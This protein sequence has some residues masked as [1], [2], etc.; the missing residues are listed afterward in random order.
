MRR[1]IQKAHVRRFQLKVLNIVTTAV[2]KVGR[3]FG[4]EVKNCPENDL[5]ALLWPLFLLQCNLTR[6]H[7]YLTIG[8]FGYWSIQTE[9]LRNL[10]YYYWSFQSHEYRQKSDEV[11]REVTQR[12]KSHEQ[13]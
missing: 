8:W 9:W 1:R 2:Y 10:W 5:D 12:Y 3:W 11:I 4:N 7:A 13:A 6:V